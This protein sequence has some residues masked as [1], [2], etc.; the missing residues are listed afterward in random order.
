VEGRNVLVLTS[1]PMAM[2]GA[3]FEYAVLPALPV[4]ATPEETAPVP[5]RHYS[6][7]VRT[8]HRALRSGS[9]VVNF[10]AGDPDAEDVIAL[11]E[12]IEE[13]RRK[14]FEALR[15]SVHFWRDEAEAAQGR[16]TELE[17]MPFWP[18]LKFA[19]AALRRR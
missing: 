1:K 10:C 18:R 6:S 12:E 19:F 17:L 14:D 7:N 2:R 15:K 5:A 4:F 3:R 16:L 11:M 8:I 13:N 9:H